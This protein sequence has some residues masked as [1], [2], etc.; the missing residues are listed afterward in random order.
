MAPSEMGTGSS[1]VLLR[2]CEE[3]T[4]HPVG[5]LRA[6]SSRPGGSSS[7]RAGN[8]GFTPS[9]RLDES[10]MSS[11][12]WE[13]TTDV[14]SGRNPRFPER[15]SMNRKD[16]HEHIFFQVERCWAVATDVWVSAVE[17]RDG[18]MPAEVDRRPL[19]HLGTA[20]GGV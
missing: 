10:R 9:G 19:Q 18:N 14:N 4:G 11:S 17:T 20:R 7:R 5:A 8:R 16:F 13:F 1:S 6:A 15:F 12:G 2:R 3:L